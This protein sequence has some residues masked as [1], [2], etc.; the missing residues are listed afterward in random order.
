ME[1]AN[2]NALKTLFRINQ[3]IDVLKFESL[4]VDDVPLFTKIAISRETEIKTLGINFHE[5]MDPEHADIG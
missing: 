4:K 2:K 3:P 1:G 5:K